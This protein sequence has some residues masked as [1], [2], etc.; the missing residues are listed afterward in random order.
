V[1][2]KAAGQLNS[3]FL[4]VFRTNSVANRSAASV[5]RDDRSLV[6]YT[7][8]GVDLSLLVRIWNLDRLK[9]SWREPSNPKMVEGE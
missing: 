2:R 7:K 3:R 8:S 6:Y 9:D 5:A 4:S 1:A